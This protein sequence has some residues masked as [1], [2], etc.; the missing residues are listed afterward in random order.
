V[1]IDAPVVS[2][3][4][5]KNWSTYYKVGHFTDRYMGVGGNA[6]GIFNAQTDGGPT[7]TGRA[8]RTIQ[9]Q[10]SLDLMPKKWFKPFKLN[11]QVQHGN[12]IPF[13]GSANYGT[14]VGLS[15]V[16]TMQNNFTL[17]VAYNQAEIDFSADPSL[18]NIGLSGDA[19]AALVGMRAFGDRW[20]AGFV[21]S[22]LENHET[23]DDGIYFEGWGSEFYGEYRL[24]NRI[25]LV[26]GYN[27]LEPDS[28]QVQAQDYRIKYAVA[29]LRYTF[30]KFR[31]M[32]FANIRFDD[33]VNA[34]GTQG[35]NI[36]TIGVR[37]DLS[38]RGWHVS[39]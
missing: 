8:D 19:R 1:G 20:Y 39:N 30:D 34:D 37:W 13:G 22:R 9:S 32:I 38:K 5:G 29:G 27:V 10:L 25:W 4:V 14:A 31:H 35:S 33:S 11:V 23:T 7:G 21:L 16:M 6:S 36:Y 28:D 3:V 17:G 26:G 18:R 24:Y 15:A 12:S 2:A